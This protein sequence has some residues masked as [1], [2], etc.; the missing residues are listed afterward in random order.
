[1]RHGF[2]L[3]FSIFSFLVTGENK[4]YSCVTAV[5]NGLITPTS[6]NRKWEVPEEY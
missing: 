1:M 2:A 6:E 4:T 5:S 3:I